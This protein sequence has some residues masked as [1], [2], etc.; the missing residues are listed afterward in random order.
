MR[1]QDYIIES[2]RKQMD[3]AFTYARQLPADKLDW[4]PLDEGRSALDQLQEL[5]Q[6][7]DY[8][9]GMIRGEK[10]EPNPDA[11]EKMVAE[12]RAWTTVEQCE[13]IAKERLEKLFDAI[14]GC[15]DE[16]LKD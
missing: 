1:F 5:A 13:S 8:V 7:P 6:S 14:R 10:Q 4:K 9:A 2:I 16:H 12:R 3:E 15:S 11:W